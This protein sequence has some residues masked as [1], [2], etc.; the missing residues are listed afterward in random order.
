MRKLVFAFVLILCA[1]FGFAQN[2]K[3][4][5]VN[6]EYIMSNIPSYETAQA[7]LDEL[8][9]QYQKEIEDKLA[10][11]DKLYKSFQAEKVLLTQDQQNKREE[12]IIAKEKEAKELQKKYFGKEGLLFK[13]RQELVKPIQDEVYNAIKAISEENGFDFVFSQTEGLNILYSNPKFDKSD[14]VLE[15]LGYKN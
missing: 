5:Y 12:E 6:V 2:Q 4:V 14:D 15:K 11:V 3:I 9:K 13:K 10:E 1:S 8:S 7:K